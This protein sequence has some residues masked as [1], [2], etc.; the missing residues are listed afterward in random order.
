MNKSDL[1]GQL[2][3]RI[4]QTRRAF[5]S[6]AALAGAAGLGGLGAVGQD[7]AP[8]MRAAD[9]PPEIDV[10][11]L[12]KLPS[13]CVAPQYI[14]QELLRT[15]GFTDIHY[16]PWPASNQ[17]EQI[18]RG[19]ADFSMHFAAP[20]IIAI[21]A[22]KP[23]TVLAGVHVGC[24][25][26]F[27][28]DGISRI[29]DLKGKTVGV[30]GTG[31]SSHVYV[32][33]MASYVGLD[34]PTDIRWVTDPTLRPM[35]LFVDGKVDAF[36]AIPPESQELRA[37]KIGH[38]IVSSITDRPW[39]QYYC[40]TLMGNT[41]FVRNYPIATKRVLRAFLK[42]TDLCAS[43]PARAARW[44]VDRGFTDHYDYALQTLSDIPYNVWR[45]YDPED[46]LRFYALRLHELGMI[47]STPQEIIGQGADWRFLNELKRELKA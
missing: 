16:V 24:F 2:S 43:D 3:H 23:I 28:R 4:V 40:C 42:A 29:G 8:P 37:R 47:K 13:I 5:L 14:A 33:S 38:V 39:S 11:R 44:V 17:H 20:T 34:P 6:N 7:G 18:A 9:P 1:L 35:Q 21:D 19:E 12:T 30:Q 32:A 31:S 15:E 25:E 46:T 26:L 41:G 36:L 22:G 45:E 27:A 10:V